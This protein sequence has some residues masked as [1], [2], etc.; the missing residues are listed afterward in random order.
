MDEAPIIELATTQQ[1]ISELMRRQDFV[2]VIVAKPTD[3][4]CAMPLMRDPVTIQGSDR[5]TA[6]DVARML[7]QAT[8]IVVTKLRV[9]EKLKGL[10]Q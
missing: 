7:A 5:L 6:F 1:L 9:E 8:E 2:G 10:Q 4:V 3:F